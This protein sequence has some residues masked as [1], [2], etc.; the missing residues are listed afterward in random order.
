ME[1]AVARDTGIPEG[2]LGKGS[3]YALFVRKRRKNIAIMAKKLL[4]RRWN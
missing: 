1:K 4:G 3:G 2:K